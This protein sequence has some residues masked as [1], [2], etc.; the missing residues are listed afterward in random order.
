MKHFK[1]GAA[2]LFLLALMFSAG[3]NAQHYRHGGSP[4]DRGIQPDTL[5]PMAMNRLDLTED[6]QVA[7]KELQTTH[8]KTMKPLRAKLMEVR[9]RE[10]TLLAQEEVDKKAVN[11]LIDEETDVLNQMKKLRLEHKL[12]VQDILTDEQQMNLEQMRMRREH[13]RPYGNERRGSPRWERSYRRN[14][15]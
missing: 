14:M 7:L 3:L 5:R 15:G 10:R 1:I 11:G 12:A 2:G 6:Q 4:Y 8:Y 13:F 9:A